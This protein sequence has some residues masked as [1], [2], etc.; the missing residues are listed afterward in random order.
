MSLRIILTS[1]SESFVFKS[2]LFTPKRKA[3]VFKFLRFEG[4]FR[5]AAF[6]WRIIVDGRPNRRNKAVF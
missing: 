3:G 1:F 2:F 6:Q 5:K 4:R